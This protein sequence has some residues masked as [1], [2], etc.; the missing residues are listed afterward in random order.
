[1]K[2]GDRVGQN[3]IITEG[4]AAG[5]RVIAEGFQKVRDGVT[6]KPERFEQ[7]ASNEG[8]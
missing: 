5:E 7:V 1:V 6:V 8:R 4:L 3:W 2:V